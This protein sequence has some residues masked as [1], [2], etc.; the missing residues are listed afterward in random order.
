M[1]YFAIF[2]PVLLFARMQAP[3][4]QPVAPVLVI[5]GGSINVSALAK[6]WPKDCPPQ[7][8]PGRRV[9]TV[10]LREKASRI[11]TRGFDHNVGAGR[12]TPSGA[13]L[14]DWRIT[15]FVSYI[16]HGPEGPPINYEGR[17]SVS[18]SSQGPDFV[19]IEFT[20]G[21]TRAHKT[22]REG[23][24]AWSFFDDKCVR[25][26]STACSVE[27]FKPTRVTISGVGKGEGAIQRLHC[28]DPASFH[29]EI[30]GRN[31]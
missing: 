23:Y 26:K 9:C 14:H 17:L 3:T 16:R 15:M 6:S 7:G 31:Q 8:G 22:F 27:D 4:Q 10:Q 5:S 25:G 20:Q 18:P 12:N 30:W 21:S 19:N 13:L 1:L 24:L 29:I 28:T 11:E 2:L